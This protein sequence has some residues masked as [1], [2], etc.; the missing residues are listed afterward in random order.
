[1]IN[2][3]EIVRRAGD[4]CPVDIRLLS[5]V[6]ERT[7]DSALFVGTISGIAADLGVS[8]ASVVRGFSWLKKQ[9]VVENF[10]NGIWKVLTKD[11]G[12][13]DILRYHPSEK[14]DEEYMVVQDRTQ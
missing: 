12:R 10:Q 8:Q 13:I 14:D 11:K 1:M 4:R 3:T 5:Y 9:G 7:S 2:L 6:L